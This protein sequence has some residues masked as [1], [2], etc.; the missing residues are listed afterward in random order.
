MDSTFWRLC[1]KWDF[2]SFL[3]QYFKLNILLLQC[4][5]DFSLQKSFLLWCILSQSEYI[6]SLVLYVDT[7]MLTLESQCL[8]INCLKVGSNA[9]CWRLN[10]LLSTAYLF[11]VPSLRLTQER[12]KN[13]LYE[14]KQAIKSVSQIKFSANYISINKYWIN[15][16]S[17][18]SLARCLTSVKLVVHKTQQRGQNCI[19][20]VSLGYVHAGEKG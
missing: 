9:L 10:L 4:E 18:S 3:S 15:L 6:A 2:I 20:K 19:I 16:S 13:C 17:H 12:I 14:T 5:K 1:V 11:G 7:Y 8:L